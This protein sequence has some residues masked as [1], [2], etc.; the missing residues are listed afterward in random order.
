MPEAVVAVLA[1]KFPGVRVKIPLLEGPRRV[2][3]GNIKPETDTHKTVPPRAS[4]ET[5]WEPVEVP[6]QAFAVLP[7]EDD[8]VILGLAT[9]DALSFKTYDDL[10]NVAERM[11]GLSV[12]GVDAPAFRESLRALL[13]PPPRSNR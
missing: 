4:V 11:S 1:R 3:M 5:A 13:C 9:I 2:K 12:R 10:S 8:I 7:G 6:P